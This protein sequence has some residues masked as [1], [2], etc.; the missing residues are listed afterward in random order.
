[1]ADNMMKPWQ[2]PTA[3]RITEMWR[4]CVDDQLDMRRDYGLNECFFRGDQWIGWNDAAGNVDLLPFTEDAPQHR[5]TVNKIKPRTIT[6]MARLL[7]TPLTFEPRPGGVDVDALRKA[8]LAGQVLDV[9]SHRD[10]WESIRRDAV[11]HA[12]FGG[13]AAV[14]L[15]PDW[16]YGGDD[17]IVDEE[18]GDTIR[19]PTRPR[20]ALSALSV[21]QFGIEPGTDDVCD[22]RW[23]IRMT[24]LTPEQA[25]IRYKLPDP[26]APDASR[27]A[28][29]MGRAMWGRRKQSNIARTTAVYVYYE[30]PSEV[31]PGCVL[32]V[33][34][35]VVVQQSGWPFSFDELNLFTFA[36]TPDAG[37][38]RGSTILSDARKLQVTINMAQTTINAHLGKVDNPRLLM[39]MGS[40]LEG[41]DELSGDVGET[42][43]WDPASGAPPAWLA[44]PMMQRWLPDIIPSM[45]A[46]MDDLFSSHATTRGQAPGDR[47]SGL[48]LSI[49]AEKDETPLGIMARNQQQGW[50]DIAE[51]VLMTEKALMHLHDTSMSDAYTQ[52]QQ[53][54]SIAPGEEAP[55]MSVTDVQMAQNDNGSSFPQEVTWTADDLPDNPVVTVP[56][57]SVMPRSQAAVQ[58]TM[59]K[60]AANPAFVKMFQNM[61]PGQLASTLKVPQATAFAVYA[62]HQETEADWENGRMAAGAGDDQVIVQTWQNHDVHVQKHNELRSSAAYRKATPEEKAFIDSHVDAHA[63]LAA[64]QMAAQQQAQLLQAQQ[65]AA[66]LGQPA[67]DGGPTKPGQPAPDQPGAQAA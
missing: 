16:E 19:T 6:F 4:H 60:M 5:A 11:Q 42:I 57:D 47:N 36:Q 43:R 24:T 28:S 54:G 26:P 41:E 13:V 2:P 9:K 38:W 12:M 64:E 34:G 65:Q 33:V 25:Q 49:L 62:N 23:W 10:K 27:S 37:S 39:P 51:K 20:T 55:R 61:T 48:A 22:A 1:M 56:L 32:H 29:V 15:E 31:S 58:D 50:Q 52:G 3:A 67:V 14:C 18:T 53:D 44:A 63:A 21:L 59:L 46:Q 30:K 7:G 66:A 35:D 8:R 17:I 45:E 40:V